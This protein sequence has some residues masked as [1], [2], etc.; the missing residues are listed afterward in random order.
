ML[1]NKTFEVPHYLL[2]R[3]EGMDR[4]RMAIAGA[5]HPIALESARQGD[6][7]RRM[8]RTVLHVEDLPGGFREPFW[9]EL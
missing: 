6:F 9:N 7:G 5:D 4:A 3:I 8:S 1:I 2:D